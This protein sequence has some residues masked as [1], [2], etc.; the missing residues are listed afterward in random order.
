[1]RFLRSLN[2]II[3]CG[4]HVSLNYMSTQS[5]NNYTLTWKRGSAIKLQ[6]MSTVTLSSESYNILNIRVLLVFIC[7]WEILT[8]TDTFIHKIAYKKD[9]VL[10][11]VQETNFLAVQITSCS[12]YRAE[13]CTGKFTG[14]YSGVT[15][16]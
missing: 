2:I 15:R 12:T 10:L 1:M 5:N 16:F 3:L 6:E 7:R 14:L 11:F 8:Y 13:W 4:L 9:D